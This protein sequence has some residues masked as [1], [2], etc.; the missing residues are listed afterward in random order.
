MIDF[1]TNFEGNAFLDTL[2]SDASRDY[3][4]NGILVTGS[5]ADTLSLF[6]PQ[7]IEAGD[8]VDFLE[9]DQLEDRNSLSVIADISTQSE[10]LVTNLS[11]APNP[12]TPNG[13]GINDEVLVGYDVQRLL[14]PR[15]VHLEFYDLGGRRVK[16]IDRELSS[17]GYTQ[18]WDGR[19]EA[20]NLVPPGVYLL[21]LSTE[22]DEAAAGKVRLISV[23]Y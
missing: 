1:R 16:G 22:A 11:V 6:L 5:E 18:I 3:T 12:F 21:R 7:P 19:D 15:A 23:V 20:G 8:V 17:G 9:T 14:T 13:D 10:D 2:E 4:A